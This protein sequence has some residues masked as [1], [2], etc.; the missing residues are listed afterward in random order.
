MS[1]LSA[2]RLGALADEFAS[3]GAFFAS[4]KGTVL[5]QWR[6]M[7]PEAKR[8]LGAR[9]WRDFDSVRALL[10]EPEPRP[11]PVKPE[12]RGRDLMDETVSAAGLKSVMDMMEITGMASISLRE[13]WF[14][15]ETVAARRG[16]AG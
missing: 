13:M 2:N 16:T 4:P 11:E 5:A 15:L 1:A 10:A 9:F 6:R 8:D 12:P 14:M 7:H 3:P